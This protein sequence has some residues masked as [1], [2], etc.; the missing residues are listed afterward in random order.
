MNESSV[1]EWGRRAATPRRPAWPSRAVGE[2]GADF[3]HR[4]PRGG[5]RLVLAHGLRL[6]SDL[7]L[8]PR[9]AR[10]DLPRPFR[11]RRLP[12]PLVVA[13]QDKTS[14]S[15]S[16]PSCAPTRTSWAS[17][18]SSPH[19]TWRP[20][21]S[22]N[23]SGGGHEPSKEQ[24]HRQDFATTRRHGGRGVL[25]YLQR[26]VNPWIPALRD[27]RKNNSWSTPS[28]PSMSSRR[29][30]VQIPAPAPRLK[31]RQIWWQAGIRFKKKTMI[32]LRFAGGVVA[33]SS[34]SPS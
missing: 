29:T 8:A 32:A 4:R 16:P 24:R 28:N 15:D 33:A 20:S 1:H 23:G 27:F 17:A 34:G 25:Q 14:G 2:A 5:E 7:T 6:R 11:P 22:S 9:A 26:W 3:Q 18:S 21:R 19:R 10:L 12:Q 31:R 30:V 13:G